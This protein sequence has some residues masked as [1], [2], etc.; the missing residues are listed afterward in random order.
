MR[1]KRNRKLMSILL[2]LSLLVTLLVPMVGPASAAATYQANTVNSVT[3]GAWYSDAL[4]T[5]NFVRITAQIPASSIVGN[6]ARV[7]VTLPQDFRGSLVGEAVG[8]GSVA[9]EKTGTVAGDRAAFAAILAAAPYGLAA[10]ATY[11]ATNAQVPGTKGVTNGVLSYAAYPVAL[12]AGSVNTTSPTL[13][14]TC[15][16]EWDVYAYVDATAPGTE[17]GTINLD[18]QS[19]YIPSSASGECSVSFQGAPGSSYTDG[20]VVVA[21]VGTGLVSFSMDQVNMLTAGTNK[22]IGIM[23]VKEDRAGAI[24]NG[25]NT[26]KLKLD[27]G[28][29]WNAPGAGIA[30][31]VWGDNTIMPTL[32][33]NFALA[34]GGRTLCIANPKAGGA[35]STAATY[36]TL[37]GLQVNID[38]SVAKKGDIQVTVLGDSSSSQSTFVIGKFGDFGTTVS[39]NNAKTV[40]AGRDG[41]TTYG[42]IGDIIIQESSP[43]SLVGTVAQP[44]TIKLT[45][46][47]NAKWSSTAV[48]PRVKTSESDLE[49]LAIGAFAAVGTDGTT[50][51]ANITAQSAGQIGGKIVLEK[52]EIAVAPNAAAQDVKITVGGTAGAEGEAGVVATVASPVTGT[53]EG[54]VPNIVIGTQDQEIAPIIITEKV[55]EGIDCTGVNRNLELEF[56]TGVVPG[57]PTKVEVTAGDLTFN[58]SNVNKFLS[59]ATGLWRVQIPITATSTTPSTIKLSGIKVNTDRTV[60]EG[61][62]KVYIKGN[63][64]VQ[65]AVLFP[66]VGSVA[67]V[68]PATCVTAIPTAEKT[69]TSVFKIG[70]TKFKVNGVEKTMDVAPY[71]KNDRTYLPIRFVAQAAGVNDAN[72]MWNDADQSVV[73]IKGDRVVKVTIGSNVMIINGTNFTMDVA[74]EIVDPGRTMLPIRWVAQA[75]G[76]TVEWD[77]ATQSVTVK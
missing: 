26:I 72:I 58:I 70:D 25:A 51:S 41:G 19:I 10:P 64:L 73:L 27:P 15:Y 37:T 11:A 12:P 52:G 50:I 49:G 55:K 33:A 32:A 45:L 22:T 75:L 21:R 40:Y 57:L 77:D 69:G 14:K 47:G 59:A 66:G 65:T 76:C 16:R 63:G 1:N 56:P 18:F 60:M 34:D 20:S 35:V 74:P 62:M 23:R 4:A 29:T 7:R 44:R 67:A 46:S 61:A 38:D 31:L 30:T 5:D 54:D 39:T 9:Y 71:T 2:T 8:G 36:Y 43:G 53:V 17:T 13:G 24:L 28:F 6:V 3:T 68:V 48:Y 42:Q